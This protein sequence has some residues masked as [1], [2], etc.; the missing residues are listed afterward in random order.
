[1]L[2]HILYG[3]YAYIRYMIGCAYIIMPHNVTGIRP[4]NTIVIRIAQLMPVWYS[5][6]PQFIRTSF[7]QGNNLTVLN[8]Q[9][10]ATI[11]R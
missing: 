7:L 1:M 10:D 2:V 9:Y 3:Y 5:G 11:D 8:I 4:T 6:E